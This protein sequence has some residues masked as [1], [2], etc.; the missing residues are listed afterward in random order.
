M[1]DRTGAPPGMELS[2]EAAR[3]L[4]EN[5]SAV[6]EMCGISAADLADGISRVFQTV[7]QSVKDLCDKLIWA[8][9]QIEESGV[10]DIEPRNRRRKRARAIE[11]RYAAQIRYWER[12]RPYRR[13]YK[14]P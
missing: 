14:Q 5:V 11:Q 4:R 10:F 8:F 1:D 12:A 2:E 9:E 7:T 6:A 13:I 3:Q